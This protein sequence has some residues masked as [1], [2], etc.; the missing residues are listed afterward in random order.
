[1]G[2]ISTADVRI[3]V[4]GAIHMAQQD[5]KVVSAEKG[6]IQKI[7]EAGKIDPEEFSDMDAPLGEDISDLSKQLSNDQAKKVFLLTLFAI[8]YADK[9]LDKSE[10]ELLDNLS[11]KLGVGKIKMDE[12]TMTA[13][14]NEVMKLLAAV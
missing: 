12:H 6:L 4:K 8:A 5:K 1:M 14:E 3:I 9:D 7:I 13:C 11:L 10:Q 2:I